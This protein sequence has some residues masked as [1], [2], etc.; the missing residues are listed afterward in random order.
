MSSP[1]GKM[2]LDENGMPDISP[3]DGCWCMTH[4][5]LPDYKCGKC[6]KI[7]VKGGKA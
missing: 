2:L 3:C 6:G 7:K 1:T 5:I 4:T